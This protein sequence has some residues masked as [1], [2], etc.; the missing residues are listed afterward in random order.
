MRP[1]SPRPWI[2]AATL[3]V[4][5]CGL[6]AWHAVTAAPGQPPNSPSAGGSL[7]G[8][9]AVG[10]AVPGGPGYFAENAFVMHPWPDNT[11]PYAYNMVGLYNPDTV[12][13]WYVTSVPLPNK[14]VITQFVVYYYDNDP[15]YDLRADLTAGE[16]L[17]AGGDYVAT[18]T[19]SGADPAARAMTAG[20]T[21][22]PIDQGL[23]WYVV[24]VQLPPTPN[25]R[26]HSFRIDYAYPAALPL[27]A[28]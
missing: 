10:T 6:F 18:L 4:L 26:F 28:R 3:I 27:I 20:V 12:A 22:F 5:A 13:H 8:A 14:A 24:E 25:V 16:L 2:L 11:V 21:N 7:T 19:S 17:Q 15:A 23:N 1:R 9:L